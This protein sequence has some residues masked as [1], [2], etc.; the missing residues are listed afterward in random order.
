VHLVLWPEQQGGKDG[1][2][3]GAEKNL[4]HRG[5]PSLRRERTTCASH[6]RRKHL[7]DFLAGRLV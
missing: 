3:R 2:A 6:R 7:V 4:P 5:W 1:G